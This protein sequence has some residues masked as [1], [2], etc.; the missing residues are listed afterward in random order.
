MKRTLADISIDLNRQSGQENLP[1]LIFITDQSAQPLPEQVIEKLPAGSLVILRD[2]NLKNRYELAVAL[3]YICNHKKII[4]SVAADLEIALAVQAD[5]IHLPEYRAT[6]AKIIR[7]N[8]PDYFISVSCHSEK[9]VS[10][11][12]ENIIDA[13]LLGPVFP[14]ESHPETFNDPALTIGINHF[15]EICKRSQKAIYALGG[16]NE[17]TAEQ[18]D[19]SGAAGIAAIRGF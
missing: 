9:S 13:V 12:P 15:S 10:K 18:L 11:L 4:F 5:G 19:G 14:T 2:Y 1:P 16:V 6:E 7:Q 3:R 17:N 8:Y